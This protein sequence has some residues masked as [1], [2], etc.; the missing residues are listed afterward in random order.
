M[1][2]TVLVWIPPEPEPGQGFEASSLFGQNKDLYWGWHAGEQA[3]N[4][5]YIIKAL[6]T[7]VTEA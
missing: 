1:L 6:S 5:G 4:K 7:K 3:G 2:M